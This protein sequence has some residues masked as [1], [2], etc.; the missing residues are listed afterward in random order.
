MM[1]SE[2]GTSLY[3]QMFLVLRDQI[4]SGRYPPGSTLPS[5][6]KL[7]RE[8]GVSRVTSRRAVAELEAAGV[9]FRQ[10]G[11]GTFVRK[12]ALSQRMKADRPPTLMENFRAFLDS[13]P[14]AVCAFDYLLAPEPVREVIGQDEPDG[15]HQR[16]IRVRADKGRPVMQVVTWVRES[17][18]RHWQADELAHQPVLRL[19]RRAGVRL[20][21]GSQVSTAVLCEPVVSDRLDVRVGAPL[22]RL[23]RVLFDGSGQP[24]MFCEILARPDRFQLRMD[25]DTQ[26]I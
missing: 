4:D 26:Q 12:D 24:Q 9:V 11:R 25:L 20:V 21:S 16:A 6:L 10:Q 18:G 8:F 22:L 19:M 13:M 15:L 1:T 7:C 14:S 17:I 2:L 5:E 23:E 3:H